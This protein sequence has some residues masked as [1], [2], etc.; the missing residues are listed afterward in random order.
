M[1]QRSSH[2]M[3]YHLLRQGEHDPGPAPSPPG[4]GPRIPGTMPPPQRGPAPLPPGANPRMPLPQPPSGVRPWMPGLMP[5]PTHI[6][7]RRRAPPPPTRADHRIPG[8]M[9]PPQ[10]IPT[11]QVPQ[12][13]RTDSRIPGPLPP[14]QPPAH[15]S[16]R[17]APTP[18]PQAQR[19]TQRPPPPPMPADYVPYRKLQPGINIKNGR[20]DDMEKRG[21]RVMGVY[22]APPPPPQTQPR[23]ERP[24]PRPLPDDYVPYPQPGEFTM[25]C[26]STKWA[27]GLADPPTPPPRIQYVRTRES[28]ILEGRRIPTPR[29]QEN[30]GEFQ[31]FSNI[32]FEALGLLD[33]IPSTPPPASVDPS[34]PSTSTASTSTSQST[35]LM[36]PRVNTAEDLESLEKFLVKRRRE[37]AEKNRKWKREKERNLQLKAQEKEIQAALP[38]MIREIQEKGRQERAQIKEDEKNSEDYRKYLEI[39]EENRKTRAKL[40]IGENEDLKEF[41]KKSK[42]IYEETV[43][44][45]LRLQRAQ[46]RGEVPVEDEVDGEAVGKEKGGSATEEVR[47]QTSADHSPTGSI[48]QENRAPSIRLAPIVSRP[49]QPEPSWEDR[50]LEDLGRHW[51]NTLKERRLIASRNLGVVVEEPVI[52]EAVVQN[53]SENPVAPQEAP[54]E[55]EQVEPQARSVCQPRT[56][57]QAIVEEIFK[58][59]GVLY[60]PEQE[61]EQ[62]AEEMQ[63]GEFNVIN[64]VDEAPGSQGDQLEE[65]HQQSKLD[66]SGA[67]VDGGESSESVRDFSNTLENNTEDKK[68]PLDESKLATEVMESD[69]DG[70]QLMEAEELL[71]EPAM[72]EV[73]EKN[74]DEQSL[75]D[76]SSGTPDLQESEAGSSENDAANEVT[77]GMLDP[78]DWQ[79]VLYT[80]YQG[81]RTEEQMDRRNWQVVQYTPNRGLFENPWNSQ[82]TIEVIIPSCL[83]NCGFLAHPLQQLSAGFRIR[84][85]DEQQLLKEKSGHIANE[86]EDSEMAENM[87]LALVPYVPHQGLAYIQH[88]HSA[89]A[90][91]LM[92]AESGEIAPVESSHEA[93]QVDDA[94][95]TSECNDH[96]IAESGHPLMD[97]EEQDP[98]SSNMETSYSALPEQMDISANEEN[99]DFSVDHELVENVLEPAKSLQETPKDSTDPQDVGDETEDEDQDLLEAAQNDVDVANGPSS[100]EG[101]SG[102]VQDADELAEEKPLDKKDTPVEVVNPDSEAPVADDTTQAEAPHVPQLVDNVQDE[103]LEESRPD[104]EEEEDLLLSSVGSKPLVKPSPMSDDTDD[105]EAETQEDVD[106]ENLMDQNGNDQNPDDT[107]ESD[108]IDTSE[109]IVEKLLQSDEVMNSDKVAP[110]VTT[111]S[112]VL[113]QTPEEDDAIQDMKSTNAPEVVDEASKDQ[114][115]SDDDLADEGDV[116]KPE[117]TQEDVVSEATDPETHV[118]QEAVPLVVEDEPHAIPTDDHIQDEGDNVDMGPAVASPA[119]E[120]ENGPRQ[121]L[122]DDQVVEEHDQALEADV[123]EAMEAQAQAGEDREENLEDQRDDRV[124]ED[125]HHP[126][127]MEQ[128]GEGQVEEWVESFSGDIVNEATVAASLAIDEEDVVDEIEL[129]NLEDFNGEEMVEPDGEANESGEEVDAVPQGE[130]EPQESRDPGGEQFEEPDME[131]QGAPLDDV[132]QEMLVEHQSSG[133]KR[134]ADEDSEHVDTPAQKSSRTDS[135]KS[136]L[137]ES[138][139]F[140][141]DEFHRA[142]F[143]NPLPGFNT[144]PEQV[145][146]AHNYPEAIER[147]PVQHE[148]LLNLLKRHLEEQEPARE[149]E[150]PRKKSKGA[151]TQVA[152]E[153]VQVPAQEAQDHLQE[154]PLDGQ[155]APAGHEDV[156][157]GRAPEFYTEGHYLEFDA[158]YQAV[159]QR[160]GVVYA[161]EAYVDHE[162]IVYA[163]Q[164][165]DVQE[166]VVNE[167]RHDEEEHDEED[168]DDANDEEDEEDAQDEEDE[169]DREE[170]HDEDIAEEEEA[171]QLAQQDFDMDGGRVHF[172]FDEEELG[173]QYGNIEAPVFEYREIVGPT[174]REDQLNISLDSEDHA[175][176]VFETVV[177]MGFE[178]QTAEEQRS[179]LQQ[180]GPILPDEPEVDDNDAPMVPARPPT[181]FERAVAVWRQHPRWQVAM[182]GVDLKLHLFDPDGPKVRPQPVR[183][184]A[185]PQDFYC[186]HRGV[187]GDALARNNAYRALAPGR[188][189]RWVEKFR[190]MGEMQ[191]EQESRELVEPMGAAEYR[192]TIAELEKQ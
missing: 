125:P 175:V 1:S 97:I 90:N 66:S 45:A 9:P 108:V 118:D 122:E 17:P 103:K 24:P 52:E 80:P 161:T 140:D 139:S 185:H 182:S 184:S 43:L 7:P 166:D 160:N 73:D 81:P 84:V 35:N 20:S 120:M 30:D 188:R 74:D 180:Y 173:A 134:K 167:K 142:V 12:R 44:E 138:H 67:V 58:D 40:G 187:Q 89:I 11:R 59:Q 100:L 69:E 2:P 32:D 86:V 102:L 54:Q 132:P 76:Q 151:E 71:T 179:M 29:A 181:Q 191:E 176:E 162:E 68:D 129:Q 186:L 141:R 15:I 148:L 95:D 178:T 144:H 192:R 96:E 146:P 119:N 117:A 127:V 78:K 128:Q 101:D 149:Q 147:P 121:D 105:E 130:A 63:R 91:S 85:L 126:L 157:G 61:I 28:I 115:G 135:A 56:S 116:T 48:G 114:T 153:E 190:R 53:A 34:Q 3:L 60:T 137:A 14:A 38:Q 98:I 87:D 50:R 57:V 72:E 65:G 123:V 39:T 64:P 183:R 37:V 177:A 33:S 5:P 172:D 169:E 62:A 55:A 82:E 41:Q 174:L 99:E 168:E 112:D 36:E 171:H 150:P 104:E 136:T 158:D 88:L 19:T 83:A 47:P 163:L 93:I 110:A 26:P 75:E 133:R 79:L 49:G 46:M 23:T 143:Q 145:D 189:A 25:P 107:K 155:D 124:L 42:K 154:L 164:E 21:E 8:P 159:Y 170:G 4:A 16:I 152:A 156:D 94:M 77:E 131:A 70:G 106:T 22:P 10:L 18:T 51:A 92:D 109:P 113:E 27:G 13:P 31:A 165:E 6:P 111:T